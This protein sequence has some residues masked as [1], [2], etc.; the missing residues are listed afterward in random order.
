MLSS[1]L[2][3]SRS[4]QRHPVGPALAAAAA[5]AVPFD[6]AATFELT[7]RPG[8][9]LQDVI[10]VSADGVF[11]AV[12]IGY[13]LEADRG[14]QARTS[15]LGGPGTSMA[16]GDVTLGDLPVSALIEGFRLDPAF[17]RVVFAPEDTGS[18]RSRGALLERTLTDDALAVGLFTG[19]GNGTD[20][21]VVFERL[22]PVREFSFLFSV[23]DSGS[24][25]EL[26]DEPIHSIAS[27]GK[28]DGERPFRML[29]QP[30]T[31][32]PRSTVRLQVIEQ[33]DD[34]TGTLFIVF[35]GYKVLAAGC[36]EPV[37]RQIR[38][39]RSHRS[40]AIGQPSSRVVPFDYVTTFRL[41]GR[42]G[43]QLEDEVSINVEGGFVATA[44]GYGLEVDDDDIE[45][46]WENADDIGV[47]ALQTEV[48]QFRADLEAWE[49]LANTDPAK[50]TKPTLDLG[51]LP[52][53]LF[54]TSALQDGVRVRPEFQRMAFGANGILANAFPSPLLDELFERVNVPDQV[55]FRYS[56]FDS[57]RGIEL[58]NQPIHNIAGL[59]IANGKRPFKTLPRPMVCVPRST[60]RVKVE[61]R[62][63]RGTL[64]IV[65][66]GF[67]VLDAAADRGRR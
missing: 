41:S 20:V 52:V 67:K 66:Q 38:S 56:I 49:A 45:I 13:G 22:K 36:A 27:L 16:P 35:Y 60:I 21:P 15:P 7:G 30:L 46:A 39:Q 47:P 17:D 59:G 25:R 54:P 64:F 37:V 51:R 34:V 29:A 58:Q 63:G 65:F 48:L 53:R 2:A 10:N 4:D 14:R 6:H 43:N 8:N 3:R 26:Q 55:S 11:V 23:V 40:E 57:G 19:T 18:S 28:S 5:P 42:P 50:A 24:G 61:E 9:V 32:L 1:S 62:F 33:S 44:V 12:A 31:F